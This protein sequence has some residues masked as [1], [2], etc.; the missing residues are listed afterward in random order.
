MNNSITTVRIPLGSNSL[1]GVPSGENGGTNNLTET[2][3]ITN[4]ILLSL[5]NFLDIYFFYLG[6]GV[7]IN[8]RIE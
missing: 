6:Q 3:I 4:N 7:E 1:R 5:L 8:P 2:N